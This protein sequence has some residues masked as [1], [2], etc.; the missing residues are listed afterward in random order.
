MTDRV[1]LVLA[2]AD[3]RAKNLGSN[4]V[5]PEHLLFALAAEGTG[6]ASHVLRDLGAENEDIQYAFS[7]GR[8]ATLE[9]KTTRLS[10][11]NRI[12]QIMVQSAAEVASLAHGYMG[13]EHLILGL[14]VVTPEL[15]ERVGIAPSKI[16]SA[17]YSILGHEI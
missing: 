1:R 5:A 6:I 4:A 12:K 17:V 9:G 13:T 8:I 2:I 15:F 11:D 14:S 7:A 3:Q 10:W 16:R